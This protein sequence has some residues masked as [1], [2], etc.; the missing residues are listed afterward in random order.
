LGKEIP[1]LRNKGN[2]SNKEALNL[3]GEKSKKEWKAA[4]RD[5]IK[6]AQKKLIRI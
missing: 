5:K 3:A 2:T 4:G 6:M 1:L